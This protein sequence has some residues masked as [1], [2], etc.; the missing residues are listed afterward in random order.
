M[1]RGAGVT[2]DVDPVQ[3]SN[4][5]LPVGSVRDAIEALRIETDAARIEGCGATA[6]LV[7]PGPH[8]LVGAIGAAFALHLPLVLSP[9]DIWLA[10]AQGYALAA[11]GAPEPEEKTKL[12][13]ER[14]DFVLGG[15]NPWPEVFTAFSTQVRAHVGPE[16]HALLADPFSTSGPLH[17][18]AREVVV[19]GAFKSFFD[20]VLVT[21]CG[22]PRVTL[23]G[24]PEDWSSLRRRAGALCELGLE[25]WHPALDEVLEQ[26]EGASRGHEVPAFW[27]EMFKRWDQSGGP[28]VTGWIN[29]L[30]PFV[31]EQAE[32]DMRTGEP[33]GTD[34]YRRNPGAVAWRDRTH[35]MHEAS[36]PTPLTRAPLVWQYVGR[37]I[38]L[39]FAAGFVGVQQ[40]AD[41]SV[42]PA[43]GWVVRSTPGMGV[44]LERYADEQPLPDAPNPGLIHRLTG[45]IRGRS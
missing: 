10:I 40:D 7:H 44:P 41:G 29:V 4:E 30:F 11:E 39:Q 20:Y 16:K 15:D 42:R 2:F 33:I 31:F 36:I 19:M 18:A 1:S 25:W 21:R 45:W 3:A 24:T 28:Y 37:S 13:V 34:G 14:S 17:Q 6:E 12:V 23:L 26:F 5:R 27:G 38:P 22:I 43:Q 32:L 8:G 35:S 9:D